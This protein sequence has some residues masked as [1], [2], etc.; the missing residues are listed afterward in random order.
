MG[1]DAFFHSLEIVELCF[2][3]RYYFYNGG[4]GAE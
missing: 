2:P 3:G 1:T 4:G